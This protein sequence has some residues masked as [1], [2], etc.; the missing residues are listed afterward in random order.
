M[1]NKNQLKELFRSL[2]YNNPDPVTVEAIDEILVEWNVDAYEQATGGNP[3]VGVSDTGTADQIQ[4][5]VIR[6]KG[7]DTPAWERQSII[8]EI[9]KVL[10]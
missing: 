10:G 5:W 8:D 3:A 7:V 6:L 2:D 9:L 4:S 1:I